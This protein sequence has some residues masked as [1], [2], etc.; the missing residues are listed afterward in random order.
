M[1]LSPGRPANHVVDFYPPAR[2]SPGPPAHSTPLGHAS[3]P[4]SQSPFLSSVHSLLSQRVVNVEGDSNRRSESLAS[5]SGATLGGRGCVVVHGVHLL[6]SFAPPGWSSTAS[7][8]ESLKHALLF[9]EPVPQRDHW[10]CSLLLHSLRSQLAAS[11]SS[12]H[13]GSRAF[14]ELAHRP[15]GFLRDEVSLAIP[16]GVP[17]V[18]RLP[19]VLALD[20]SDERDLWCVHDC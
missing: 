3:N 20:P 10:W 17:H 15:E 4:S 6:A 14:L 16:L 8:L 18:L 13:F 5:T 1:P 19:A 2:V 12:D 9:P 11:R 7:G